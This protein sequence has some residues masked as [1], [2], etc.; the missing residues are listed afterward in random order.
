M[1]P[2]QGGAAYA[3]R[4]RAAFST[5]CV[6]TAGALDS[7]R[8]GGEALQLQP[9]RMGLP[10]G[11]KWPPC[12]SLSSPFGARPGPF[13][14]RARRKH[15]HRGS[16]QASKLYKCAGDCN[17]SLRSRIPYSEISE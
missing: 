9:P 7:S 11:T 17:G 3:G 15:W 1:K 10:P 12:W 16:G 4:Q 14:H 5:R 6:P 8:A 2:F 13:Q